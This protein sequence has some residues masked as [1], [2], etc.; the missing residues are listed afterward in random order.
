MCTHLHNKME[1][2]CKNHLKYD[3]TNPYFPSSS[4]ADVAIQIMSHVSSH[5]AVQLKGHQALCIHA[6]ML[7]DYK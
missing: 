7:L 6:F 3:F 2:N 5:D 1:C 4:H